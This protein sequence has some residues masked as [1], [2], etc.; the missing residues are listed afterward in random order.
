MFSLDL[1]AGQVPLHKPINVYLHTWPS[2]YISDYNTFCCARVNGKHLIFDPRPSKSVGSHLNKAPKSC[3][4]VSTIPDYHNQRLISNRP[5]V[6][7]MLALPGWYKSH[8]EKTI[9][10]NSRSCIGVCHTR[11]QLHRS[12]SDHM[13]LLH[14]YRTKSHNQCITIYNEILNSL[15]E[16]KQRCLI[17]LLSESLKCCLL[18]WPP[19]EGGILPS[20]SSERNC[21]LGEVSGESSII[22]CDSEE[23]LILRCR[24]R[25]YPL[26]Y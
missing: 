23:T 5:P 13:P 12:V 8:R 2:N 20:Q 16:G 26:H 3:H 10:R 14:Q 11:L 21:N 6:R 1:L 18:L 9:T 7:S 17:E 24:L 19:A 15:R 4:V 22:T 25:N